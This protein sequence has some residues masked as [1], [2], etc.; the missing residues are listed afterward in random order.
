MGKFIV[1]KREF[2]R[3]LIHFSIGGADS[4]GGKWTLSST[5][6][7]FEREKPSYFVASNLIIV[8]C[9]VIAMH[10]LLK[11]GHVS[12]TIRSK[13]I[14]TLSP[15]LELTV[16]AITLVAL[17]TSHVEFLDRTGEREGADPVGVDFF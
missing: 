17:K 1:R 5:D 13:E 2:M 15:T 11:T 14:S 9:R 7:K 10:T 8:R 12:S 4:G 3:F 16:H 6:F